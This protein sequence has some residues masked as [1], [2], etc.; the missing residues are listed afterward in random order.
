MAALLV[1]RASGYD[2]TMRNALLL[3]AMLVLYWG[4]AVS[5]SSHNGATSDERVHL[6]GGYSYWKYNDYRLQPENGNLAMRLEALP[7]LAMSL[8]FPPL[9]GEDWHLARAGD[10]GHEFLFG[11]GNPFEKMLARARAVVAI[12]GALVLLLVWCW[13]RRLFGPAAGWLALAIA[14]F[15]P[16][17]LAHGGLATSDMAITACLF[18]ATTLCW[19][20]L[21]RVT[22]P[23]LLGTMLAVGA[24]LL[25][26]FS[27][28][29]L[30]PIAVLLLLARWLNP[31]PL[32]VEWNGRSHWVRRRAP[33]IAV[34]GILTV[35]VA[36]G[37]VFAIW[38]AYG[39]RFSTFNRHLDSGT[40]R[41]QPAWAYD[42]EEIMF[43]EIKASDTPGVPLH[44]TS[45]VLKGV[46][47]ARENR[48]LPESYLFGFAFCYKGSRSRPAF[49][50]GEISP[51]GW[52][53]FFPVAF[54]LKTPPTTLV[55]ALG[56]IGA[57]AA[58]GTRSRRTGICWPRRKWFYRSTPL[59]GLF[60][61]YWGIA[62]NTPLN[63]GHRHLLPIYPVVYVFAGGAAGWV[64][65]TRRR[66]VALLLLIVVLAIHVA[67]SWRARPNYLGYFTPWIGGE[68]RGWKYL[69]D[70]SSD[71]GQGLPELADWIKVKES[72]GDHAAVFLTY[73]GTDSPEA[74]HL[75]V[76][77][78]GDMVTD[79]N[80]RVF[81]AQVG[82]GWF[83]ISATHYQGVYLSNRGRWDAAREKRYGELYQTLVK[84]ST[85]PARLPP[86]ERLSL[87]SAARDF[88]S[89][90]FGR[91]RRFL[92]A[93]EP[94]VV[95]GGSLLAFRLSAG[96]VRQALYGPLAP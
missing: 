86:A 7:L 68:A 81:P 84:A 28:V 89:L 52:P 55:L 60:F 33:L 11:L 36:A 10:V 40:D 27:G 91:L 30:A 12:L 94:D 51:Q 96:E 20:L 1:P 57:L 35:T 47:W 92:G 25:A 6:V 21:H 3:A 82:E 22:W 80:P 62:I 83:V 93:R 54:L 32:I 72:R 2:L 39:F 64:M 63:I 37:A 90:Q 71:W 56:G 75:A 15:C 95:I 42:S 13:A 78:F 18:L 76:T 26:K 34:T 48:V 85:D 66:R 58:V 46:G 4:M 14:V 74:R 17:M 87:E 41:F 61:I 88:E 69:V 16:T 19:Q 45:L 24:A 8:R 38:G 73:F 50:A 9:D 44:P 67:D 70:S 49:L 65:L 31:S 79:L 23:R 59:L 29:I 53:Q 43:P 77:R 5:V